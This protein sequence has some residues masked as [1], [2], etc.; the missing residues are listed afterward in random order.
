EIGRAE[1][2]GYMLREYINRRT[3]NTLT[4][5]IALGRPGPIAVHSPEVC[6]GGA[7]FR[8]V[9]LKTEQAVEAD[10]Q[11]KPA[12][13]WVAKFRK[14]S[15]IPQQLRVF[16][17]FPTAGAWTAPNHPRMAFA[18][19]AVLFKIYVISPVPRLD[20]PLEKDPGLDFLRLFMPELNKCLF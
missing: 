8:E 12:R 19:N 3:G 14:K 2:R 4:V 11:G 13:F 5:L 10:R 17:S 16:W 6:F 9:G 18:G 7:G 1:I 15:P 20:E